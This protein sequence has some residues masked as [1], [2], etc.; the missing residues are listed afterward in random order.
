MVCE[1]LQPKR[2][3]YENS[4]WLQNNFTALRSPLRNQGLATKVPLHYKIISQP[5][6]LPLQKISQLQNTSLAHE[7]HFVASPFLPLI[8]QLRNALRNALRNP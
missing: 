3:P 4:H 1:I 2:G 6:A 5:H 7:C 8:S